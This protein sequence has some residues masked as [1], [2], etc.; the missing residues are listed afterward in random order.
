MKRLAIIFGVMCLGVWLLLSE[1]DKKQI[2]DE[3]RKIKKKFKKS[4]FPGKEMVSAE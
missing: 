2:S 4:H 3:G 1:K